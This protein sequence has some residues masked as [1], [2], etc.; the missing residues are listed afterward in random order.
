[1]SS[2]GEKAIGLLV[3]NG[4]EDEITVVTDMILVKEHQRVILK[5]KEEMVKV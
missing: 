5:L 2:P 3:V 4:D 1:M